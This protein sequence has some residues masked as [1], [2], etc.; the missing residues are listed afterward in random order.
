MA[1]SAAEHVLPEHTALHVRKS[2]LH[3]SFITRFSHQH[4]HSRL[5][6]VG[7]CKVTDGR[8]NGYILPV[9]S[10]NHVVRNDEV[11]LRITSSST[12]GMCGEGM[13]IGGDAS[14]ITD[15]NFD[16]RITVQLI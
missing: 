3:V 11:I 15:R 14:D 9:T 2:R 16:S 10:T 1:G 12:S 8:T 5:F 6:T 7:C 4:R 13:L